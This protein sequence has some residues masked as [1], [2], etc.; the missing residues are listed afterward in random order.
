MNDIKTKQLEKLVEERV[1]LKAEKAELK[2]S[3]KGRF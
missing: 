2:K 1:R 3:V